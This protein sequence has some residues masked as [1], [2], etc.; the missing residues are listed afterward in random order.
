MKPQPLP[1]AHC[2]CHPPEF[3]INRR[4]PDR[5]YAS[6]SPDPLPSL[7]RLGHRQLLLLF[8]LLL[9]PRL[10]RLHH[11]RLHPFIM[12]A[13]CKK[14]QANHW[15]AIKKKET[16]RRLEKH[17]PQQIAQHC[18]AHMVHANFPE[19]QTAPLIG[20][21]NT[22]QSTPSSSASVAPSILDKD[23]NGRG[24]WVLRN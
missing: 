16:S 18:R 17:F 2:P 3:S 12:A 6:F 9:T 7:L 13:R 24:R 8:R 14:S 1:S 19:P 10:H 20:Q 11:R 4:S 22:L 15:R 5:S 21:R 23:S